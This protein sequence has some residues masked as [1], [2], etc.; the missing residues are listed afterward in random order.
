MRCQAA[1]ARR[2]VGGGRSSGEQKQEHSCRRPPAPRPVA[3]LLLASVNVQR[4]SQKFIQSWVN[5]AN[6]QTFIPTG[7]KLASST[8]TNRLT[9][10]TSMCHAVRP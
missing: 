5:E 10:F 9:R 7:D 2:G 1:N 8:I 6:Q 3:L 4:G